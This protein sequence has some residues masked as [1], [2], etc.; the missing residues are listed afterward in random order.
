MNKY[1]K[2][3]IYIAC[4]WALIFAIPSFYWAAGGAVG[5]DTL[6]DEIT[7]LQAEPWFVV[8]VWVTAFMKVAL[9]LIVLML[10]RM[11]DS[12]LLNRAVRI[13]VWVAGLL[14]L[15]YG[16]LNLLARLIMAL[17]IIPTPDAMYSSAAMWHL[18]LWDPWWVLGGVSLV[19][20]V[21]TAKREDDLYEV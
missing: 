14:C 15:A 4:A 9:G 11:Y 17:G 2:L 21:C 16:G 6:G 8:F 7:S 19:L 20:A 18:L 12:M 13:A 1:N 10:L 3:F 5:L